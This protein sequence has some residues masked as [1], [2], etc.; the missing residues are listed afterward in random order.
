M[1][2]VHVVVPRG[3]DDPANPSG[4]NR[5]DLMVCAGL[6]RLGWGVQRHDADGDWP[7]A[8]P[9]SRSML[10]AGL[11]AVVDGATVFLDG[12]VACGAPEVVVP[13]AGRLRVVVLVHL[14]LGLAPTADAPWDVRS[15]E[16]AVLAAATVV[17]ATSEWTRDWLVGT[18]GLPR[19][20]VVVA[21][22][23]VEPAE[24][25]L[26]SPAGT[27]LL[28]VGAVTP[29]KGHDVLVDALAAVA[30]L[31]WT[32]T[33]VGSLAVDPD[34]ARRMGARA[35][36]TGL[37]TRVH[38]PGPLADGDLD[39]AFAASDLLVAPSRVETYG[40]VVTESL[41][42]GIPV[43]A[44]DIGGVPESVGTVSGG[45]RPGMLVPPGD[46]AALAAALRQWLTDAGV[47]HDLRSAARERRVAL[48]GWSRTTD[49][50]SGILAEVAA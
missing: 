15:C 44:S 11:R 45:R 12:L 13:Q 10:A 25:V 27:R 18:Y 35:A 21:Q 43:L 47:R 39:A 1:T 40:M 34:F 28:T 3:V 16:G 26:G 22:P 50:V 42:R 33:C 7:R 24:A 9:D 19:D 46:G 8:D 5:Y 49:V 20:R 17:V 14:P 37:G 41:A 23:G 2:V 32:A 31:P 38:F 29:L 4:G 30:D 6:S 48:P 36:G